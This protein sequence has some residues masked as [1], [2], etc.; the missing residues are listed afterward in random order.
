NVIRNITWFCFFTEYF[1]DLEGRKEQDPSLP[2]DFYSSSLFETD[3]EPCWDFLLS[4]QNQELEEDTVG[5]TEPDSDKDCLL[6]EFSS[7]PLLPCYHVQV[8]LTQGFCNWFLLTDVLKRLKMSARIFRARYPHLEVV[9]LS[10][11]ELWSQVSI[12]QVSSALASPYRGKNKEE[13]K[14]EEEEGLVDLVR[15]VPELQRLLGSSIHILQD[16]E[17]EEE[18]TLTNTGKPRSR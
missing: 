15:C 10:R 1:T 2:W 13:D 3:Q 8:S 17:E 16:E 9:S 14:E 5:K 18:E 11:A 6:F 7:E 4:E 12:S